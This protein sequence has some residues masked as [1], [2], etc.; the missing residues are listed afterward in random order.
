MSKLSDWQ[1][2]VP[3]IEGIYQIYVP[4]HIISNFNGE[5]FARFKDGEWDA[6]TCLL[7]SKL[8]NYTHIP[9]NSNNNPANPRKW[10]GV[11]D[12]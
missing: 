5:Y 10:R 8:N 6:G 3:S 4:E 9:Y 11:I 7:D 1:D 12:E 2:G